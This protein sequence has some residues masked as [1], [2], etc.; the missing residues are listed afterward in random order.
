MQRFL[1]FCVF[2][3]EKKR[4]CTANGLRRAV[5]GYLVLVLACTPEFS[6]DLSYL[7]PRIFA[8]DMGMK[9]SKISGC[10]CTNTA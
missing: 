5:A 6:Q 1:I 8:C 10:A 4:G 2:G 9:L 7:L 3:G